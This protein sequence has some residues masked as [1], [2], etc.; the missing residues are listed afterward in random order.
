[1]V[2]TMASLVQV[3]SSAFGKGGRV[4]SDGCGKG[5]DVL[6]AA[7]SRLDLDMEDW[8]LSDWFRSAPA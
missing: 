1:M 5:D 3:L 2:L 7:R 6:V 4:S 8:V